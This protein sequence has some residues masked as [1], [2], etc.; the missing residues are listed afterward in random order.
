MLK[1]QKVLVKGPLDLDLAAA[2]AGEPGVALLG[3]LES[4]RDNNTLD[5]RIYELEEY[6][7]PGKRTAL[8][9]WLGIERSA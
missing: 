5:Y 9:A 6:D 3:P 2:R 1:G 7:L 8:A 4:W